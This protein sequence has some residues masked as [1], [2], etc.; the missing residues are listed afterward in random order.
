[1]MCFYIHSFQPIF[2]ISL[3]ISC[4]DPGVTLVVCCLICTYFLLL[5]IPPKFPKFPSVILVEFLSTEIDEQTL[6]M[7]HF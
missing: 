1:M 7:S 5:F 3:M 4:F 2:K 6:M